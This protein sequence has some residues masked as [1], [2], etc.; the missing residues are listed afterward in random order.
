MFILKLKC[1]IKWRMIYCKSLPL[2]LQIYSILTKFARQYP[3]IGKLFT[4]TRMQLL[5]HL[6]KTEN[7]DDIVNVPSNQS[8]YDVSHNPLECANWQLVDNANEFEN[9]FE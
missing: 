2:H 1:G 3:V 7:Q 4:Q 6:Y 5:S 9:L 8:A